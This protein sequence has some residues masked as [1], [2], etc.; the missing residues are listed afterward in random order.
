MSQSPK[1]VILPTV[2]P[3]Q[4]GGATVTTDDPSVSSK[5][6]ALA[7]IDTHITNLCRE[8]GHTKDSLTLERLRADITEAE[9]RKRT[10]L[11]LFDEAYQRET[12]YRATF[13]LY[14]KGVPFDDESTLTVAAELQG[15][16]RNQLTYQDFRRLLQDM[17]TW[18]LP[19]QLAK[20]IHHHELQQSIIAIEG[21]RKA[22]DQKVAEERKRFIQRRFSL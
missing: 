22:F 14:Q 17:E 18:K 6:E 10:I 5:K 15:L 11:T 19:E 1:P 9:A 20:E 21:R 16:D 3:P 12:Q 4:R 2:A 13:L 8:M 7:L